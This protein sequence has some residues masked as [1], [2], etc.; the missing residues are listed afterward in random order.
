M[1]VACVLIPTYN[2]EKTIRQCVLS[3]KRSAQMADIN[4]YIYVFDNCS[5]DKTRAIINELAAEDL[6]SGHC[7]RPRN[8]GGGTFLHM[9]IWYEKNHCMQHGW[10]PVLFMD[11]ED[12]VS[13]NF[14]ISL[15]EKSLTL[16]ESSS[17][18]IVPKYILRSVENGSQ[19]NIVGT[20]SF[21]KNAMLLSKKNRALACLLLPG[22]TGYSTM[23]WG[24]CHLS[25]QS[26][27][28]F[29]EHCR[30]FELNP[31]I[32]MYCWENSLITSLL[33]HYDYTISEGIVYRGCKEGAYLTFPGAD[34]ALAAFIYSPHDGGLDILKNIRDY[35][36]LPD[37]LNDHIKALINIRME[38]LKLIN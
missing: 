24:T 21:Y 11:S 8:I 23:V 2:S 1:K 31:S 18:L 22:A 13:D 15:A 27:H 10:S 5:K 35:N 3:I 12:M 14:F 37:S 30:K 9:A 7:L 25:S 38:I 32:P 33:Y 17:N 4:T 28:L 26:F 29:K 19:H 6:I 16:E 20:N 34:S 36:I